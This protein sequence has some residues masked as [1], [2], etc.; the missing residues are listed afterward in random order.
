MKVDEL[1]RLRS[2]LKVP[3]DQLEALAAV[4]AEPLQIPK[5]TLVIEPGDSNRPAM[6]LL[7]GR[8]QAEIGAE[9]RVLGD[10][11]PGE[12]FGE[13]ALFPG[14]GRRVVGVRAVFDSTVLELT[15]E[16]LTAI[17]GSDV[18]R[19]IQLNLIS[20][21]AKRIQGTNHAMRT[22]WNEQ[23]SA[24][25]APPEPSAPDKLP[26]HKPKERKSELSLTD[27]LRKSL[28]GWFDIT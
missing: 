14:G 25:A 16:L 20:V 21:L 6:L 11:W 9:C 27:R 4:A 7:A 18:K 26:R 15:P 24:Q 12:I 5:G 19:T 2:L 8:M 13:S 10:V 1:R 17:G 3:P 22:A 28:G 23:R